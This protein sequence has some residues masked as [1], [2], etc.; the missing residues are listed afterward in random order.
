PFVDEGP[1]DSTFA[2]FRAD[3][4]SKALQGDYKGVR[5]GFAY[6]LNSGDGD[7]D[8]ASLERKWHIGQSP[9]PFLT[10]LVK[11]LQLGGQFSESHEE[12]GAPYVWTQFPNFDDMASYAVVVHRPTQLFDQPRST[13]KVVATLSDEVAR[14]GFLTGT[15][16]IPIR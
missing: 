15:G 14:D 5:A 7:F 3:L 10:E 8:V 13:A 11:V 16:W 6:I 12:F 1:R 4:V 9:K 2:H